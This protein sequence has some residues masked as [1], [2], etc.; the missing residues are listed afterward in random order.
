MSK[1]VGRSGAEV[2]RRDAPKAEL[3][4]HTITLSENILVQFQ[5]SNT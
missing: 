2:L 1:S 3:A 5:G 4:E